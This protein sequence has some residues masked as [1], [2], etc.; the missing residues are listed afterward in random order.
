DI[1]IG[2]HQ[3]AAARDL[4]EHVILKGHHRFAFLG[5]NE[6][7][8][9]ALERFREIQLVIEEHGL[10][11]RAPRLFDSPPNF[12]RGKTGLA[13]LLHADPEIDA[14]F[15]PND[16]TAIGGLVHCIEHG[17]RVPEDVALAGFSGLA[18]GQ[19]M[20]QR[21]TTV[22][23]KRFETGQ[24]AATRALDRLNERSFRRVQDMGYALLPGQTV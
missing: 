23:T 6:R 7:D 10:S 2:I 24:I 14:V 12:L 4:A 9:A 15:F 5:W 20:P 18:M 21:L 16:T 8:I 17:I 22:E 3:R 1:N 13:Q 11:I 19:S